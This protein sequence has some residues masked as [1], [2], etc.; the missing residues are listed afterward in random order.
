[1]IQHQVK[2]TEYQDSRLKLDPDLLASLTL[3]FKTSYCVWLHCTRSTLLHSHA[4]TH[5]AGICFILRENLGRK[6]RSYWCLG[7]R[8]HLELI[9]WSD[10]SKRAYS[11]LKLQE[12]YPLIETSCV[13]FTPAVPAIPFLS[14][15]FPFIFNNQSLKQ[16]FSQLFH[17]NDNEIHTT[18]TLI[19]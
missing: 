18:T 17:T 4:H 8:T 3:A 11:Y 15:I 2:R 9:D 6:K 14:F 1:M 12:E 16:L 13:R 5:T 19:Y 10:V 7:H